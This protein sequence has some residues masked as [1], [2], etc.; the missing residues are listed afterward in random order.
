MTVTLLCQS[1]LRILFEAEDLA[2]YGVTYEHLD[3]GTEPGRRIF[4]EALAA[5]RAE[6]G[7][8][9]DSG[10]I[11]VE[12]FPVGGGGCV[13]T[14]TKLAP[15]EVSPDDGEIPALC[16]LH[17][18]TAPASAPSDSL[19]LLRFAHTDDLLAARPLLR[20]L[21]DLPSRLYREGEFFFLALDLE[22]T[23]LPPT[24]LEF[25]E[26]VEVTPLSEARL[27]ERGKL[28][29]PERALERL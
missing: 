5:A 28:L 9:A 22:G 15:S 4:R 6:T 3:Y 12:V 8:D 27:C 18:L 2:R 17:E 1:K 20:A 25:C 14:V 10:R 19:C 23:L 11:F 24:L 21:R 7:F 13:A 16:A 29:F 26:R